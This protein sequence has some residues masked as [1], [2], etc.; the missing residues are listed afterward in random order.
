MFPP[1]DHA[2]IEVE[3]EHFP[4]IDQATIDIVAENFPP[5]D[6]A[7]IKV[8]AQNF[9]PNDHATIDVEAENISLSI[10]IEDGPVPVNVDAGKNDQGYF[11]LREVVT[12]STL[13][14]DLPQVMK[15]KQKML[16]EKLTVLKS[17]KEKQ[18]HL[19]TDLFICG[20]CGRSFAS[21]YSYKRHFNAKNSRCEEPS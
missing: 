3:V 7:T 5:I 6:H 8:E 12:V 14:N 15:E 13:H 1:I 20:D 21:N 16:N 17:Y 11:K 2:T 4:P 18:K 19:P 10:P 9:Q